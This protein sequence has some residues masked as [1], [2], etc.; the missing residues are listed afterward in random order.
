MTDSIAEIFTQHL[1][2]VPQTVANEFASGMRSYYELFRTYRERSMNYEALPE[3]QNMQHTVMTVPRDQ[4]WPY[5]PFFR[6]MVALAIQDLFKTKITSLS[7]N[8]VDI[9]QLLIYVD[10]HANRWIM[11]VEECPP[12]EC[13]LKISIFFPRANTNIAVVGRPTPMNEIKDPAF[14]SSGLA[15]L[16]MDVSQ[17]NE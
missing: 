6:K 17:W 4:F 11:T 8:S 14:G 7:T 13:L 15:I 5:T 10:K 1:P 9:T 16:T 12:D 2:S 3:Y